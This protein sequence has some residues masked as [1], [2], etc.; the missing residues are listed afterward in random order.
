MIKAINIGNLKISLS[1]KPFVI[2]ELGIN[3]NGSVSLGKELIQAAYENGAD[4]IKFQTYI[5]DERFENKDLKFIHFFKNMELSFDKEKT[6]WDYAKKF[7]K[8]IFSTPF[9]SK[10]FDFCIKNNV[11][12]IKVASFETTNNKLINKLLKFKKTIFIS[13]GQNK[14]NEIKK[15]YKKFEKNKNQICLMH[16]ISSYPTLDK[17]ANIYRLNNLSQISK[18]ILGYSDH[19]LGHKSATYAFTLGAR[20]F[21]KHFTLN[22]NL[23]GPDHKMS[24]TPK[25]LKLFKKKLLITREMLGDSKLYLLECE[26]FIHENVR[27]KS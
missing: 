14:K 18:Y 13:T 10:S 20:F 25:E 27:R 9:D 15:I 16:C 12:A 6:L 3:H 5:T 1:S 2:A 19:T 11:D 24:I 8:K 23:K 22:K 4:A 26:K 21:E 17:D 7:K